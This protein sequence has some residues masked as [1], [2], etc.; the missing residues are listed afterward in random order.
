MQFSNSNRVGEPLSP[1]LQLKQLRDW[2]SEKDRQAD[3]SLLKAVRSPGNLAFPSPH[4]LTAV[5]AVRAAYGEVLEKLEELAAPQVE[6]WDDVLARQP[7]PEETGEL[8]FTFTQGE[9]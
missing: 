9:D 1:H 2:L 5:T 3:L 6:D 7:G 4:K 8:G